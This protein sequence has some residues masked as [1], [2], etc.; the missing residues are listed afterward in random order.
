VN[1]FVNP[2]KRS[3]TLPRGCKDLV[4]VLQ[5]SKSKRDEAVCR[6][7]RLVLFQAQQD[8]A[9]E[10]IVGIASPSEGVPIRYKIE[11]AWHEMAT[12][13][14]HIRPDVASELA[15]MAKFHAGQIPGEGV[16]DERFGDVRLL[17]VVATMN[18]DGECTLVR[19]P[20]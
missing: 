9:T 3:I 13:P 14:A 11:G 15:R 2:Q 12:F 16:L 5:H 7:I 20:E 8:Q 4:D 17:W 10:V 18:A 19:L 1:P 6:F